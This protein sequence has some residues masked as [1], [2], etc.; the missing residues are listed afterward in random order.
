MRVL[1]RQLAALVRLS[2]LDLWRR[3]DVVG[4]LILALALMVPLSLSTPF[5]ASG[6]TRY[7]DEAAL[8]LIWGFSLFISLGTGARLFPPEFESRTIYPLLAKPLSRTRLLIGKYLGAVAASA[9]AL[10]FFYLLFALSVLCRGGSVLTADFAQALVF[11]LAFVALTVAL[12]LFGSLLVT[13]SANWTVNAVVLLALF[14]FGRRLPDYAENLSPALAWVVRLVDLLAPHVE[15][16]D[17]RQRVVHG[18]GAV[19]G[20]V[21]AAVLVYAAAYSAV[22]LF[23]ASVILRRKRF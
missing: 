1:S 6:A 13:A 8:L 16:F 17:M 20:W 2:F 14:F 19:D 4:L 12:S 22:L 23:L 15:F 11:H 9:S 10:L 18:W 7:L 3:N 21:F 5:G